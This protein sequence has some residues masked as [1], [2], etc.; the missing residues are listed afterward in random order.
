MQITG[1]LAI[2][3][4]LILEKD[5]ALQRNDDT[6]RERRLSPSLVP[7]FLCG[8]LRRSGI[9]GAVDMQY[10]QVGPCFIR[11]CRSG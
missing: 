6:M 7:Y 1:K 5:L 9:A 3:L 11:K 10:V 4:L 2:L 8:N